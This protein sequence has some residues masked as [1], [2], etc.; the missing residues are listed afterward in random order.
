MN[1]ESISINTARKIG[2]FAIVLC[3]FCIFYSHAE[4][5]SLYFKEP[6]AVAHAGDALETTLYFDTDGE[7]INAIE[8]IVNFPAAA[9]ELAEIRDGNSIINFWI[10]KPNSTEAS[11]GSFHFSGIIPGGFSAQGGRVLSLIFTARGQGGASV[12]L[13]Q[14]H[15][16]RNDPE[17]S[18]ASLVTG[19]FSA[20]ILVSAGVPI[21]ISQQE[22]SE[23]PETFAPEVASNAD[24]FGGKQ[25]AVFDT[26]DKISGIEGYRVLETRMRWSWL[27]IFSTWKDATSPYLLADQSGEKFVFIKAIDRA[28]NARVERIAP[29]N[30]TPWYRDPNIIIVT[31]ITA[32]I[33]LAGY[34]IIKKRFSRAYDA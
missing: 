3:A 7:S 2:A 29:A 25:F 10:E 12:A 22:D 33:A 34:S 30:P 14:A 23:D 27:A 1:L 6:S 15:A 31:C 11:S 13:A 28:G 20:E 4:G 9:L 8:G 26:I 21:K 19:S 5:A 17:A 32:L 18:E 24:L 16:Y